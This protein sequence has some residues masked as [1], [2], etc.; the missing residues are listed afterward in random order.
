MGD[1]ETGIE[2]NVHKDVQHKVCTEVTRGQE[3]QEEEAIHSQGWRSQ[4]TQQSECHKL[5][6]E[7]HSHEETE[8]GDSVGS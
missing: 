1:E 4:G 8:D 7:V 3:D 2:R 6:L 5:S